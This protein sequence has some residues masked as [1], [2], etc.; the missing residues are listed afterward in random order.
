MRAFPEHVDGYAGS[1]SAAREVSAVTGACLMTPR[2]L[3]ASLGGFSVDYARHYQ[4]V[5]LCLRLRAQGLRVVCASRPTLI[6]HESLTRAA[7]GYDFGDRALLIDRW[8][9]QIEAADPYF[10]RWLDRQKLDYSVAAA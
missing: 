3:F 8:R 9:D 4:D 2:R 1:L 5:D 7:D 10:S 6:H